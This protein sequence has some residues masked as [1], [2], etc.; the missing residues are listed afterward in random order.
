MMLELAMWR[1]CGV[2]MGSWCDAV[3]GNCM[4]C[5]EERLWKFCDYNHCLQSILL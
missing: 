4:E 5:V 2:M 3:D 1:P